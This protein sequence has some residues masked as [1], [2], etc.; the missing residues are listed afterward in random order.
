MCVWGGRGEAVDKNTFGYTLYVYCVVYCLEN[1]AS[2][3]VGLSTIVKQTTCAALQN[4]F[5]I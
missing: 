1:L 2:H 3:P 5:C 4:N